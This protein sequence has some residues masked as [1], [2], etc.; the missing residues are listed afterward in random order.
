MSSYECHI[1]QFSLMTSLLNVLNE[2]D[3]ESPSYAL[4]RYFLQRFDRLDR[5]NI[6]DVAE[7]C[8]VSRSGIQ[9][10][11]KSIGFDTFSKMKYA[12]TVE[13]DLYK[14]T[15]IAYGRR[16]DF[17]D[18]ARQAMNEMIAELE[19]QADRE[20]LPGLA[21]MLHDSR[22]VVLLSAECS[23]MA[24]R[25]LQQELLASGK[26]VHLV[27]DSHPDFEL[28]Q[29]LTEDDLVVVCSITGNYAYALNDSITRIQGPRKVLVTLNRD[30]LFARSYHRILY[31]S[32]TAND[33][34]RSVFTK[35]GMAYFLDLLY[36]AYLR[37]YG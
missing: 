31:L 6:Y 24:P 14:T 21:K 32:E 37:Q 2:K 34:Q 3:L 4:A 5:L 20:D 15:Y 26:L 18:Y 29:S 10:F 23:S 19:A 25:D 33:H 1:G 28:L 9:R 17:R 12:S 27:T 11:C 22:N 36:N 8:F 7:E 13:R 16:A 30:S 35:Y